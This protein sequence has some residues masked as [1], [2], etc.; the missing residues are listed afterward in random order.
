MQIEK[1][2]CDNVIYT[3]LNEHGKIK[4][5]LNAQKN[6]QAMNIR[7]DLWPNENGK[8]LP[9]VFS[10][11]NA[12]K[13]IFLSR[14]KNVLVPDGYLSNIFRC[15]D[16]KHRKLSGLKSH[17]SHILMEQLLPLAIHNILLDKVTVVLVELCSLFRQLC[18]KILNPIELEKLQGQIVLTLSYG[19]VIS[20]IILHYNG[21]FNC[22]LS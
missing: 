13:D 9:V 8:Y 3:L 22:S 2:V 17:G 20:T 21:S 10:L 11:T 19:D 15:V 4:D 16:L 18:G 6:L 5:H 12:Q 7:C 14:L 1:N